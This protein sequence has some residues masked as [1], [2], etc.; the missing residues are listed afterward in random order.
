MKE[1]GKRE[2]NTSGEEG[3]KASVVCL[4]GRPKSGN[5]RRPARG[6][7]RK[8]EACPLIAIGQ[9]GLAVDVAHRW[10]Q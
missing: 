10:C 8:G 4:R 9:W 5:P 6:Q 7:N 1:G 2:D 3:A